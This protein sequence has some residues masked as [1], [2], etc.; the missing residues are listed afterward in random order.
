MVWAVINGTD[1]ASYAAMWLADLALKIDFRFWIVALELM[2]A[3]QIPILPRGLRDLVCG[4]RHGDAG[5]VLS[6]QDGRK[7]HNALAFAGAFA[8]L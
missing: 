8:V 3:K 6:Q 7:L 4:G 2:S 1:C 5:D